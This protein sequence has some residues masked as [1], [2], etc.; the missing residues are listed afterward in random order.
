MG[1]PPPPPPP[2]RLTPGDV[3]AGAVAL[4]RQRPGA[5]IV[6]AIASALPMA[7]VATLFN[8]SAGP[9]ATPGRQASALVVML[10]AYIFLSQFSTAGTAVAVIDA[11]HGRP[12][13]AGRSLGPVGDHMRAV[14]GVGVISGVCIA[15]G[16]FVLIPAVYLA[17]VWAFAGMVAVTE[18]KG[19]V[20][21]LRR[22]SALVHRSFWWTL[23]M[24]ALVT[25]V[26]GLAALGMAAALDLV[27]TAPFD[28]D[29]AI[30]A[31]SV[32]AFVAGIVVG[33][34]TQI[35]AALIYMHRHAVVDGRRPAPAPDGVDV[36][37]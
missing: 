32:S 18:R 21:A 6:I 11:R 5:Y 9:G 16:A 28:G 3:L 24:L 34:L 25:V 12:P 36:R 14:V 23:G 35:A 10:A 31:S 2:A 30:V 22:S 13:S 33:P 15:L 26:F 7:V 37:A 1:T 20:D 19:A 8:L 29:A 4:Y 17:V 27:I